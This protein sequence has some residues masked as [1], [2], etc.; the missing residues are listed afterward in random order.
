MTDSVVVVTGAGRGIGRAISERFG[1]E[2]WQVVAASR[3]V[4]ELE[5]TRRSIED[6]GG[7]CHI[8]VVDVC[9]TDDLDDLI[10]RT[11]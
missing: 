8:Q 10:E 7:R 6:A 4:A 11:V 2:G 5:E 1:R 9:V 3:T